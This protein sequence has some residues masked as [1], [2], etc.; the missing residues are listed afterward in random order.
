MKDEISEKNS[1]KLSE[2]KL[3]RISGIYMLIL[4]LVTFNMAYFS[5]F[6][7]QNPL[8]FF[9]TPFIMMI[10]EASE[11]TGSRLTEFFNIS[12]ILSLVVTLL[13]RIS[14]MAIAVKCIITKI[15]GLRLA[16]VIVWVII[17]YNCILFA[18]CKMTDVL[19]VYDCFESS[20][21]FICLTAA[22]AGLVLLLRK[23]Q[24]SLKSKAEK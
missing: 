5:F 15:K 22:Q 6:V 9:Y 21:Y 13:I 19:A 1:K 3:L 7:L 14:K 17:A 20:I 18:Y 10:T 16:Q 4:E 12:P 2:K 8:F 11:F 23:T 24:K